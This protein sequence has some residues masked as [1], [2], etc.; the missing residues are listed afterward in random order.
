MSN[1]AAEPVPHSVEPELAEFLNR[2]LNA[3]QLS[4]MAQFVAPQVGAL[5][6]RA[7]LGGIVS[8]VDND[9]PSSNGF[10]CCEVDSQGV[11]VWKKLQTA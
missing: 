2:Q 11:G 3:I 8:L 6:Q 7:I 10:Y 5:P 1:Y 4:F 9:N